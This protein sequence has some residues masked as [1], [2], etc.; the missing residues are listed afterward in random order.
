MGEATK[1]S[2]GGNPD[3]KAEVALINEFATLRE[4]ALCI[5]DHNLFE[6]DEETM[7]LDFK[8]PD[9]VRN[10]DPR[11]GDEISQLIGSLNDFERI[12]ETTTVDSSGK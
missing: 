11:V 3:I 10:L 7:K 9:H 5:A 12:A 2:N 4:F 6:D 1:S 8:K